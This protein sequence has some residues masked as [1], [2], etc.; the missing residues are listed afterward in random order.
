MSK[1]SDRFKGMNKAD[2][3]SSRLPSP[4][5]GKGVY[6]IDSVRMHD[7]TRTDGFRVEVIYTCLY[8]IANGTDP[9]G[10]EVQANRS[11]DKVSECF[12]SGDYFLKNFKEFC[13]TAVGKE[14]HEE[15]DIVAE[16]STEPTYAAMFEGLDDLGKLELM[17]EEMLPGLV[18]AFDTEG[19]PT[20][21][22]SFDGNVVMELG[23]V[24]KRVPELR[25]KK[26]GD[27]DGNYMFD[28]NGQ[29][30][31]KEYTNTYHN[32]KVSLQ[33]VGDTLEEADIKRFFGSTEAFLEKMQAE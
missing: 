10:N 11:G 13:L 4:S 3:K 22:G 2:V 27:V 30:I 21:A 8:A 20:S 17:W 5:L 9:D 7:N 15:L 14:P 16:L 12:F 33:E 24:M 6:K 26:K 31:M 19:N 25:D 29:K 32:R 18:C 23:T 1:M 28:E